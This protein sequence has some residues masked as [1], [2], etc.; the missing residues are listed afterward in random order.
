MIAANLLEARALARRDP[1]TA[2]T[3][4]AETDFVLAASERVVITGPSG[5]GKSVL[6]RA[7]ALLDPLDGGQLLW[8]GR[9]VE[10]RAIPRFR[11]SVAYVRQRPALVE[12]TVEDNL[13]YPYSLRAYRDLR[14]DRD[15]AARLARAAGRG[16]HFLDKRASDLSGGEAQVTALIRVLQLAPEVLLLDEPTASLDPD[17]VRAIEALVDDWFIADRSGRASIWVSHDPA[18]AARVGQR[19]L[20]M[21]A[22]RLT[23][24]EGDAA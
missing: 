20:Q 14:F 6:L 21:R 24:P 7:L 9:S 4:L 17:T 12:G 2:A 8:H 15:G 11:R 13:R 16:E 23:A 18:Q 1:R 22:G 5:S 3:L 10:R 19:H